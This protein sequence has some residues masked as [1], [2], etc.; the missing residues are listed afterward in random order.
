MRALST[1]NSILGS[2]KSKAKSNRKNLNYGEN[3]GAEED[4]DNITLTR[5]E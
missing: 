4:T 5:L 1:G 2:S 3:A